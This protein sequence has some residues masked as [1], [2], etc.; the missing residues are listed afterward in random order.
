MTEKRNTREKGRR[1]R[2]RDGEEEEEWGVVGRV[3]EYRVGKGGGY[4]EI[5]GGG[6][7][8][9]GYGRGSSQWELEGKREVTAG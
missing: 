2:A 1:E 5:G 6:N 8:Q 4:L 7:R 9:R 3:V